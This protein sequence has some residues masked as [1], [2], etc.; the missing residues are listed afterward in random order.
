[1]AEKPKDK[2]K[3]HSHSSGGISFGAEIL[4]FLVVLFILWVLTGGA[5]TSTQTSPILVP[6]TVNNN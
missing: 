2:S 4:I 3:S 5:K 6:A 1:M